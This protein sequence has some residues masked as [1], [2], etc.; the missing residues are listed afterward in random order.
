MISK[1]QFISYNH[2]E[3]Q[4]QCLEY[5]ENSRLKDDEAR[6]TI[7][8]VANVENVD[9]MQGFEKSKRDEIIRMLKAA[10]AYQLVRLLE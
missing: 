7:K 5:T 9:K 3:N 2:E 8:S 1:E 4:D 6:K 10:E